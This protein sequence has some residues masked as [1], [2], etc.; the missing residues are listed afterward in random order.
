MITKKKFVNTLCNGVQFSR[1]GALALMLVSD[2]AIKTKVKFEYKKRR[3]GAG[4]LNIPMFMHHLDRIIASDPKEFENS[5]VHHWSWV[6][7]AKE[8]KEKLNGGVK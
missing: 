1:H 7:V 4:M 8:W 3:K 2:F 6:D 5:I